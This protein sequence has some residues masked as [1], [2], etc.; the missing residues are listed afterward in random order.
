[1][2]DAFMT[3]RNKDLNLFYT[4]HL[5][6]KELA[7]LT[8]LFLKND[9][10]E[11]P[12]KALYTEL[13]DELKKHPG[14][15][16]N[17][18]RVNEIVV[19]ILEMDQ[20]E[21][22]KRYRFFMDELKQIATNHDLTQQQ[23]N[24]RLKKLLITYIN[25]GLNDHDIELKEGDIELCIS[26]SLARGQATPYSDID[27]FIIIADHLQ[28]SKKEKIKQVAKLLTHAAYKIALSTNQFIFDPILLNPAK[29]CGTVNE[30]FT[31]ISETDD[32]IQ[33]DGVSHAKSISTTS[34]MIGQLNALVVDHFH[35][36][37]PAISNGEAKT[38][39]EYYFNESK[40][41][42]LLNKNENLNI[43]IH[44]IRPLQYTIYAISMEAKIKSHKFDMHELPQQLTIQGHIDINTQKATENI[45]TVAYRERRKLHAKNGKEHDEIKEIPPHIASTLDLLHSTHK[46]LTGHR[47]KKVKE[48]KNSD[49]SGWFNF[50]TTKG[51]I[52]STI[53]LS[54][55]ITIV[56]KSLG[57][58]SSSVSK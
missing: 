50:F 16:F 54:A 52:A 11:T 9:E 23:I 5:Q 7:E 56:T 21:S 4:S 29:L 32:E 55:G 22:G 33:L 10:K 37:L 49:Q 45:L 28:D 40:K 18:D 53:I 12:L 8:N 36:K 41:C 2:L 20:G 24:N 57:K 43:K 3:L 58:N 46:R 42:L 39:S 30:L 38:Y 14:K 15:T 6:V 48:S 51:L 47:T 26:G 34:K 19:K 27:S 25:T 13:N 31:V 1:M 17:E 35:K 44:L